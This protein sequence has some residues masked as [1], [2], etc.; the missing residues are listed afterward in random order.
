LVIVLKQSDFVVNF[1]THQATAAVANASAK[2]EDRFFVNR[3]S[4]EYE[5]LL[6][7]KTVTYGY[8]VIFFVFFCYFSDFF[9]S[10]RTLIG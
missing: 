10:G 4:Q 9:G 6:T 8:V 5:E 2:S 7:T 1:M 3:K